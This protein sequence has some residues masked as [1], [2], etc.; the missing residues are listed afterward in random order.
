MPSQ[1]SFPD[2]PAI[3]IKMGIRYHDPHDTRS[4]LKENIPN[5]AVF[6]PTERPDI[7]AISTQ[8]LFGSNQFR[9]LIAQR[10]S[11]AVK[12]PTITYD[13]M[14]RVGEDSRWDIFYDLSKY[15]RET[16]PCL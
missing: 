2:Y 13:E 14:G 8:T 6:H 15:L 3:N 16:F 12:I 10:L 5:Q 7:S 4:F 1:P 11:G 9:D